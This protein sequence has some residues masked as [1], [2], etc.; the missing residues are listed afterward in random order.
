M[1]KKILLS[2][3]LLLSVLFIGTYK[4]SAYSQINNGEDF[5]EWL[6]PE[7]KDCAS[8]QGNQVTLNENI[9]L[10]YDELGEFPM[11]YGDLTLDLNGYTIQNNP[12]NN[13]KEYFIYSFADKFTIK[14]SSEQK[15]GKIIANNTYGLISVQDGSFYV[16]GGNYFISSTL[17]ASRCFGIVNGKMYLNDGSIHSSGHAIHLYGSN[18]YLEI[19]GGSI[20]AGLTGIITT[21]C[22]L[23]NS[24]KDSDNISIYINDCNIFSESNSSIDVS[25]YTGKV[26]LNISGG[27]FNG[28]LSVAEFESQKTMISLSGGEFISDGDNGAIFFYGPAKT[29]DKNHLLN[30]VADGFAISPSNIHSKTVTI[31]TLDFNVTYTDNHVKILRNDQINSENGQTTSENNVV[32]NPKTSDVNIVVIG[33]VTLIVLS[34]VIVG[35]RRLKKLSK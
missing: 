7:Q 35:V 21:G 34:G 11:I 9:N 26:F 32:E 33:I 18:S 31:D 12:V 3:I 19:N 4:V 29:F 10:T 20:N 6:C 22:M 28:S 30:S 23:D 16:E 25:T 5:V 24:C 1:K 13:V 2:S 8:Y 14:D 15:S 17:Q 27:K